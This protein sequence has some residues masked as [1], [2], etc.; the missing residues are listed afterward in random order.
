[1][2]NLYANLVTDVLSNNDV[3][4]TYLG[5]ETKLI[6]KKAKINSDKR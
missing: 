6:I 5:K 2:P 3:L 4:I 1:M